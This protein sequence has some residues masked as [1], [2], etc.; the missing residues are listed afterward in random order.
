MCNNQGYN[1]LEK[2]VGERRTAWIM[3][4]IINIEMEVRGKYLEVK[5]SS[6]QSSLSDIHK[7]TRNGCG[8][9]AI[10]MK[11]KS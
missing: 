3:P 1:T 10:E 5:Y 8:T 9:Q 7:G 4:Q 11:L 2:G 6:Y